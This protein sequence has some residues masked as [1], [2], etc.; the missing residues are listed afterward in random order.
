MPADGEHGV[1]V[2]MKI[3]IDEISLCRERKN[4][5]R[6]ANVLSH[7]VNRNITPAGKTKFTSRRYLLGPCMGKRG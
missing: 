1:V 4:I 3:I 6:L 7:G 2:R 5:M